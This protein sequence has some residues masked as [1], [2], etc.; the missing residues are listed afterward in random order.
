VRLVRTARCVSCAPPDV[1]DE[2]YDREDG[3][4]DEEYGEHE[5]PRAHTFVDVAAKALLRRAAA[6][7]P[8]VQ[9]QRRRLLD[10]VCRNRAAIA[11]GRARERET[12][13][14]DCDATPGLDLGLE[15]CDGIGRLD[16]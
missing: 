2:F 16:V 3:E 13:L 9:V 12:L 14:M 15:R 10:V 5:G 4:D 7:Q 11:Q 8:S 1:R 6:V